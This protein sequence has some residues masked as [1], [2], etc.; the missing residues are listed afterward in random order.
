ML[1]WQISIRENRTL[2]FCN[3]DRLIAD[4]TKEYELQRQRFTGKDLPPNEEALAEEL[5]TEQVFVILTK[6]DKR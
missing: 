4:Y 2:P 1:S 5:E 3:K 6:T